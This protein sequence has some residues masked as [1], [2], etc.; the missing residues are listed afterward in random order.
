MKW[1]N[2]QFF[3]WEL[4]LPFEK[5]NIIFFYFEMATNYFSFQNQNSNSNPWGYIFHKSLPWSWEN[6]KNSCFLGTDGK[7][8]NCGKLLILIFNWNFT[9]FLL[10]FCSKSNFF[11]QSFQK[12][13]ITDLNRS[14]RY[15]KCCYVLDG[16]HC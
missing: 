4:Y 9:F 7:V 6:C 10:N 13:E 2:Q 11:N 8:E 16:E 15:L 5:V 1:S 12:F 3:W 14:N